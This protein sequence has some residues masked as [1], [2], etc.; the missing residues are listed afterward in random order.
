MVRTNIIEIWYLNLC[1]RRRKLSNIELFPTCPNMT[2]KKRK[3]KDSSSH[4]VLKKEKTFKYLT[5]LPFVQMIKKILQPTN[6]HSLNIDARLAQ[7]CTFRCG[8]NFINVLNQFCINENKKYYLLK[9][10]KNIILSIKKNKTKK[11]KK[12]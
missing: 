1:S 11:Y 6:S 5:F 12:N 8:V 9:D 3:K 2:I 10:N 7:F 4:L